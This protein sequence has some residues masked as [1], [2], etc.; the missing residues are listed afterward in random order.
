MCVAEGSCI[1]CGP[2]PAGQEEGQTSSAVV[3]VSLCPAHCSWRILLAAPLQ[4]VRPFQLCFREQQGVLVPR[5]SWTPNSDLDP[6]PPQLPPCWSAAP[7][8]TLAAEGRE[9]R[10]SWICC[11]Q[12]KNVILGDKQF[13]C[14]TLESPPGSAW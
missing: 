10:N 3:E 9:R 8:V 2:V 5:L 6:F 12:T 4:S 13:V 14:S 1:W 7:I 11:F